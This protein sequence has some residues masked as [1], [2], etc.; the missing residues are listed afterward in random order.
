MEKI[1]SSLEKAHL[2]TRL[3]CTLRVTHSY[4]IETL[5]QQS[6][7]VFTLSNVHP[8]CLAYMNRVFGCILFGTSVLLSYFGKVRSV[9][10]L[11]WLTS[12]GVVGCA[13]FTIASQLPE[14][15]LLHSLCTSQRG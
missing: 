10:K 5:Y 11:H 15:T 7:G 8:H 13:S 1:A 4:L 6:R 3:V 9:G 12:D 14:H 2:A